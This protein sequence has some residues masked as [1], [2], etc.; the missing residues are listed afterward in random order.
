MALIVF[1]GLGVFNSTQPDQNIGGAANS[2]VNTAPATATGS[3]S[4][5]VTP[6]Q[7][8]AGGAAKG[9]APN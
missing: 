7:S 3:S 1:A 4:T 8:N 9:T 2:G 6:G 5:T